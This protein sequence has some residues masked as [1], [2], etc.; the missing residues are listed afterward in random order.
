[1]KSYRTLFFKDITFV[2][3]NLN[4]NFFER[5]WKNIHKKEKGYIR[6]LLLASKS[7]I[8][9]ENKFLTNKKLTFEIE[10]STNVFIMTTRV[11]L[12]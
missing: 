6:N 12:F 1:M 11:R 3:F 7:I 9:F 10:C 4:K 5:G 2:L 8:L